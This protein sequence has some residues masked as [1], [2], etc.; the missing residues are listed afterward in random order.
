MRPSS[1]LIVARKSCFLPHHHRQV[2]NL[3]MMASNSRASTSY[4]SATTSY[5]SRAEY[6][7][8]T[9]RPTTRMSRATA[10]RSRT[11]P[12]TATSTAGG[13]DQ[14]VICA[15]SESRGVSPIVGLAFV[16]LSTTEVILCQ[17]S[18][19]QTY[20]RTIHK[21]S[22]LEPTEILFMNTAAQPASN[23]YSLIDDHLH[24]RVRISVIDRKFWTETTGLDY[25]Q[26]LAFKQDIE[27]LKVSLEGNFYA[28]C[29]FAAVCCL[30]A[31][32]IFQTA[33]LN[34]CCM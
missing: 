20:V 34:T 21:L 28:T 18:D 10:S 7:S 33:L 2:R 25:I 26:R 24:D 15:I 17:I 19:S 22:I 4:T 32:S 13:G 23:L 3:A 16:N 11:R 8:G 29:C 9:P 30:V 14:Q 31:P 12:R 27:A 6:T 1:N 5:P